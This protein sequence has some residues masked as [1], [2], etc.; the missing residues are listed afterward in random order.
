[1]LIFGFLL[2]KYS[3][4]LCKFYL[5]KERLKPEPAELGRY[6]TLKPKRLLFDQFKETKLL[7]VPGYS[8]KEAEDDNE[9][10]FTPSLGTIFIHHHSIIFKQLRL[11]NINRNST[12]ER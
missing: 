7:T 8:G 2:S 12:K 9:P 4:I 6:R 1:M 11:F 5:I 10:P 3:Y